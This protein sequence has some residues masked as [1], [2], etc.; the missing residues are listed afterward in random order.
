MYV[1]TATL[2]RPHFICCKTASKMSKCNCYNMADIPRS[3][4][5]KSSS[6]CSCL[7][8][9]LFDQE[10]GK[11]NLYISITAASRI[12]GNVVIRC[13]NYNNWA[14]HYT[15]L[16]IHISSVYHKTN[17]RGKQFS[18]Q[19]GTSAAACEILP[20]RVYGCP[21]YSHAYTMHPSPA[22]K[23]LLVIYFYS[24]VHW[25]FGCPPTGLF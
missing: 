4:S 8:R 5:M 3:R 17:S 14:T 11:N 19:K 23:P 10:G 1:R 13:H 9:H 15:G 7:F 18:Q 22:P 2:Q 21:E 12:V 16:Y 20:Y 6:D 24:L 25:Y